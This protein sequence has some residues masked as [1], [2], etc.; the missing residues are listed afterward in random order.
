M[1]DSCTAIQDKI[2]EMIT[3]DLPQQDVIAVEQHVCQC[4]ICREYMQ[5][6]RADDRLLADYVKSMQ[7]TVTQLEQRVIGELDGIIETKSN[8]WISIGGAIVKSKLTRYAAAAAIVIG[9]F[10]SAYFLG[11][12]D[13]SGVV[14]AE[15]IE[16]IE[17]MPSFVYQVE[18]AVTNT[19]QKKDDMNLKCLVYRSLEYGI[20]RDLL[21]N[22]KVVSR[23]FI[24]PDGKE[25]IEITPGAKR[26]LRTIL[27]GEKAM[28]LNHQVDPIAMV[29]K[30]MSFEHIELGRRTIDDV[31]VEGIEF[32]ARRLMAEVFDD[33]RGRLW[34]DAKTNLPVQ[35]ELEGTAGEGTV[36][37]TLVASKFG[38]NAGLEASVFETGITDDYT[39]W[40]EFDLTN[41]EKA[42]VDGL[43]W[44]AEI[45]GGRYPSSMSTFIAQKEIF[46]AWQA[47]RKKESRKRDPGENDMKK[48]V[49]IQITS[50]FYADL[51]RDGKDVAYYGKTVTAND[52]DAVLMGWDV[53][54]DE[55]RIVYGDLRVET[56]SAERMAELEAVQLK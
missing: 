17:R 16:N 11:K 35:I 27:S 9:L 46:A 40:A 10:I 28:E 49:G 32:S 19:E 20:R 53:S 47:K 26:Y 24:S 13:I 2:A 41:M 56:V 8:R 18:I 14:L 38:W 6:L 55:C 37:F 33:G 1:S 31:E 30:I 42:A 44:F 45:A 43:R 52:V 51:I 4:S 39:L 23:F 36:Q 3:G 22:G 7:E 5:A 25:I 50:M 21:Q 48:M 29:R 15:V 54:Q 12:K 34:V